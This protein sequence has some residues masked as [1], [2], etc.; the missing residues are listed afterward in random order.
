MR[1]KDVPIGHFNALRWFLGSA[2][3]DFVLVLNSLRGPTL[4][5]SLHPTFFASTDNVAK[6]QSARGT[7]LGQAESGEGID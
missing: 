4:F 3:V 2:F 7:R 6:S 1:F 5:W